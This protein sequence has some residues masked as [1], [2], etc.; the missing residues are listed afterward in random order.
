MLRILVRGSGDVGSAVAFRLFQA[1]YGVIIHESTQPTTTRRGMAFADAV[2][3]GSAILEGIESKNVSN[4]FLLQDMLSEHKMIPLVTEDLLGILEALSPNVL[5]DARMRKHSQPESQIH[6]AAL[7][8]GLGPNFIAGK[9]THFVIETARGESLGRIIE[10]GSASPLQGEPNEIEGHA[11]DRYVYAPVAGKF[12]TTY[13]IGDK[14]KAGEEVARIDSTPL[15]APIAGILRGLTHTD[16]PVFLKTK[17]IE[18]DPRIE[19]AQ[20]MGIAE[21]PA[22]IAQGVLQTVQGWESKYIQG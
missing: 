17:V 12:N 7:T 1:G 19:N 22:R 11:R 10:H 6:L 3:D 14:V 4:L 5:V 18:I 2:F 15:L 13:Q 8:V 21:R 9:T 20:V 16:V